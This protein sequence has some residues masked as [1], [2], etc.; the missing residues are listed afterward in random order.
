MQ[1]RQDAGDLTAPQPKACLSAVQG[2]ALA[3]SRFPACTGP[4]LLAGHTLTPARTP[5]R[6]CRQIEQKARTRP[7]R[8]GLGERSSSLTGHGVGWLHAARAIAVAP[9]QPRPALPRL[10]LG[11]RHHA[12]AVVLR[13]V[14]G[15]KGQGQGQ[16]SSSSCGAS[17]QSRA[18][19]LARQ[20]LWAGG[21]SRAHALPCHCWPRLRACGT[22]CMERTDEGEDQPGRQRTHHQHQQGPPCTNF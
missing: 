7:K 16:V 18:C 10:A 15:G 1:R 3:G 13:P 14:G 4:A 8:G 11:Y 5:A 19:R 21:H 20:A 22:Q 6:L 12:E 17:K 9:E 2:V